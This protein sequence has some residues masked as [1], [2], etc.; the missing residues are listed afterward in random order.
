V[1]PDSTHLVCGG[2]VI[3]TNDA[4]FDNVLAKLTLYNRD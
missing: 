2:Q 3:T 4:Q 1:S